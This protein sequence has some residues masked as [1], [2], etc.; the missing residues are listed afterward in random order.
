M[1][2]SIQEYAEHD[3]PSNPV[4]DPLNIRQ[5]IFDGPNRNLTDMVINYTMRHRNDKIDLGTIV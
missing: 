3:V 4:S 2:N 5:I 1:V